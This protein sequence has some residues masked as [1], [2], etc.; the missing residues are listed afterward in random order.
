[1]A[2]VEGVGIWVVLDRGV[3]GV[4]ITLGHSP[5]L[6]RKGLQRLYLIQQCFSADSVNVGSTISEIT[7]ISGDVS[8]EGHAVAKWIRS[9]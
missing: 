5:L 2:R 6:L 4:V 9:T 1:M 3:L 8:I 7:W